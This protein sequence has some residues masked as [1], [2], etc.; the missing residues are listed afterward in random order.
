MNEVKELLCD[1]VT[2]NLTHLRVGCTA[3][4]NFIVACHTQELVASGDHQQQIQVLPNISKGSFNN[5][6]IVLIVLVLVLA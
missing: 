5:F 4:V 2:V 1:C 6:V 3:S